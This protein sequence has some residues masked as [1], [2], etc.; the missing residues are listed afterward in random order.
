MDSISEISLYDRRILK[1]FLTENNWS[2]QD[3]LINFWYPLRNY[4]QQQDLVKNFKLTSI[5]GQLCLKIEVMSLANPLDIEEAVMNYMNTL[6]P[7]ALPLIN[8]FP[9]E[10]I[11][12]HNTEH[13]QNQF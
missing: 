8:V 1:Q 12:S 7:L 6:N 13:I 9:T 3:F 4:L 5:F 2:E 11:I 10:N